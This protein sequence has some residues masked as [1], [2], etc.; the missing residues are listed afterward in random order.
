MNS[1]STN[2]I[3]LSS[4]RTELLRRL[5]RIEEDLDRIGV[6]P[7]V[8]RTLDEAASMT[9][10]ILTE[11]IGSLDREIGRI[12]SAIRRID[13]R[14]YDCCLQ[15]GATIDP[16]R[17][18]RLPHAVNCAA[19]STRHHLDSIEVL[20]G[21]H[22]SLR[23]TLFNVLHALNDTAERSVQADGDIATDAGRCRALLADLARHLPVR[24]E[25]EERAGQLV[26]AL[27]T[28]PRF[29]RRAAALVRQHGEFVRRAEELVKDAERLGSDPSGLPGIRDRYREFALDLLGHEQIESDIV[30]SAFLDDLGGID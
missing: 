19:C 20:R 13:L 14:E 9:S 11:V 24:F 22:S 21:H 2:R 7:D 8:E 12:E 26:E 10:A 29:S 5:A 16:A 15:C 4:R 6:D 27:N 30:E 23:R 1:F 18:E 28:A 17:L 3:A 25:Q